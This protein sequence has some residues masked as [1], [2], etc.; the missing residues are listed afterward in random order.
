MFNLKK[1]RVVIKYEARLCSTKCT[2]ID[3][4]FRVYKIYKT[5]HFHIFFHPPFIASPTLSVPQQWVVLETE[6]NLTCHASGYH[7]PPVSFSWTRDGQETPVSEQNPDGTYS[8]RHYL[9]MTPEQRS[10]GGMVE[11]AVSQPG[12]THFCFLSLFPSD[13]TPVLTKSAKASVA[14]MCISIVLVFLLCF[15]FSWRRRDG[16]CHILP[17]LCG[18]L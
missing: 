18:E 6:S 10:L 7:P 13:V 9:T 14:M 2:L 16:E 4:T 12:L 5:K 11:C 17:T 15:G 3:V 1:E 8:T